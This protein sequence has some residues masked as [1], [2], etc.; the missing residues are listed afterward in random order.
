MIKQNHLKCKEDLKWITNYS[1]EHHISQTKVG[2]WEWCSTTWANDYCLRTR[3]R[4]TEDWKGWITKRDSF[5]KTKTP[6]RRGGGRMS[7][8]IGLEDPVIFYT[9]EVTQTKKVLLSL[10][11]IELAFIKEEEDVEL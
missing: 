7:G 5:L 8:D 1:N 10:K 6:T 3:N 4:T 11:G 9:E 2:S